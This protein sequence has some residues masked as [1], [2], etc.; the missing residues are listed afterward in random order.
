LT[1]KAFGRLLAAS[2]VF[3]AVALASIIG[4]AQ[5][6]T[7]TPNWVNI[8]DPQFG[9]IGNGSHDDT[10]AIQ[11]AIDYAFAH[12]RTAVYCPAG[13][14]KTSSTIYLDPPGNLRA[15]LSNPTNFAFS[16]SFF[17]D[18]AAGGNY[19]GC[20]IR[21]TFNNSIAFIV[22]PGQG[23]RVSDIAVIGPGGGYR[24]N[25]PSAGV[26]IGLSGGNG[27][28]SI[29]LVEDT[30]VANFFAL[31]KTDANNACCLN[32]SNTFRKVSGD[33]AYYGIN[34]L[35]TQTDINDVVEPRLS[36]TIGIDSE[37]SRQV[38]VFGGN[39]SAVG[40]QSAS[41][42]LS[43][44][45]AFSKV[46]DG[47]GYDYSF[48]ATVTSPDSYVGSVY[49][50]YMIATAHF[51]IV[52]L[53]MTNWNSGTGVGTF[54]IW[55]PWV[56]ANY[57]TMDLT[58]GTD[59]QAEVAAVTTLYA[60]E[61]VVVAQGMGISLDG[62]HIEN[63]SACTS[64]FIEQAGWGGATSN[65]VRNP[66]L[67]YDPSLSGNGNKA[68]LYCQQSFP[69]IGQ[70]KGGGGT[71]A[72]EGGSYA[73]SAPVIVEVGAS[74][75]IVGSRLAGLKLNIRV[76]DSGGYA[77]G[78]GQSYG[79]FTNQQRGGGQWDTGYTLPPAF[80][81]YTGGGEQYI[82]GELIAPYCGF[83]PCPWTTPNLPPSIYSEVSGSLGALGHYPPIACRTVYKSVDWN[84]GAL[85][86]IHLRSASC[87]GYSWGQNLTDALV[88]EPITW[89]YK[90]KSDVLYL[91]MKTLNFM[92]SGLGITLDNGSG[93]QSYVVTGIY[94]EL[95]YV[96]VWSSFVGLAGTSS[97]VYSCSTGCTIGQAPYAWSA[98]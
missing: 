54:Q 67:N 31:Y 43:G 20:S 37:V 41:F 80:Y 50:S 70:E 27:G 72:L 58:T 62:V 85:A 19:Q 71:L 42:G 90:G 45:S 79:Q 29:N 15:N 10:A 17:G 25:Q 83:E 63:P 3:S 59:I 16:M 52:P 49:N 61:R 55:T 82:Q 81:G 98:Y 95:G 74:P 75:G 78:P 9:A 13:N 1:A 8:K 34:F 28:S 56:F 92:F 30:Y 12:N 66:Y 69:F 86:H 18:P 14:Y 48:T 76:Y 47:N 89:A 94:P 96:T 7:P 77:Y 36:A 6:P 91:D 65:E 5:T 73:T 11:A 40:G 64:L 87:P 23:M 46:S 84:S 24:A 88:G 68:L 2:F 51:G 97:T 39:I 57:S 21:P 33:N 32:D 4:R 53:T 60:T 38:N 22:G 44:V 35:G 93:P 26:G